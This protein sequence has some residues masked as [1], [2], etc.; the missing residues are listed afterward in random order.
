M[1]KPS[2]F[3]YMDLPNFVSASLSWKHRQHRAGYTKRRFSEA[4][5]LSPS[6]LTQILK[7]QRNPSKTAVAK[8]GSALNLTEREM[9]F[10]QQLG[11]LART[12][13][14][15]QYRELAEQIWTD[16]RC[17]RSAELESNEDTRIVK[18][19][20][21]VVREL[22]N[23]PNFKCE[24]AWIQKRLRQEADLDEIQS[25]LSL[26]F[27]LGALRREE[28][29][30]VTTN[31]RLTSDGRGRAAL[32][33]HKEH[34]LMAHNSLDSTP[35]A[36]RVVGSGFVVIPREQVNYALDEFDRLGGRFVSELGATRERD[37]ASAS[38][39]E[40]FQIGLHLIP[41]TQEQ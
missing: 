27:E 3:D 24:P 29:H 28:D 40:L 16:G 1:S 23:L 30:V 26:L 21:L 5:E 17:R 14:I 6:M 35:T 11:D 36:D 4:C 13:S 25:A 7:R 20:V 37:R 19:L 22:A 32:D 38:G 33:Y 15:D 41:L 2:P 39:M 34:L 18:W 10:L 9:A 31:S 12:T 8:I